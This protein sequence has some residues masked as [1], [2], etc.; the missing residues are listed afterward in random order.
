LTG[1]GE[2]KPLIFFEEDTARATA[3]LSPFQKVTR[4]RANI[5]F[6]VVGA[7]AVVQTGDP[8]IPME[9]ISALVAA[10]VAAT[11]HVA[12]IV[13]PDEVVT[14][15][16]AGKHLS[17]QLTRISDDSVLVTVFDART[18]VGAIVFF[19]RALVVELQGL[20][21]HVRERKD[22]PVDLGAGFGNDAT[23]ALD[24]LLGGD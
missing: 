3:A 5:L 14:V 15:T 1:A 18:T 24:D 2:R 21:T 6:D 8:G 7:N 12:A 4:T 23:G 22:K 13:P 20:I 19:L 11:R 10:S 16:H 9:T 17:I